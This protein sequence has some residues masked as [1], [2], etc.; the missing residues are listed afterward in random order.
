VV[1][2]VK[3]QGPPDMGAVMKAASARLAGRAEGGRIAAMARKLLAG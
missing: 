3:P 1:A 2:E